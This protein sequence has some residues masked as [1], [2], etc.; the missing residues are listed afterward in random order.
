MFIGICTAIGGAYG[1]TDGFKGTWSWSGFTQGAL[2]G[3]AIGTGLVG[4]NMLTCFDQPIMSAFNAV[5]PGG[6][7]TQ[8]GVLV[9]GTP[10][11]SI[12]TNGWQVLGWSGAFAGAGAVIG[13]DGVLPPSLSLPDSKPT[14]PSMPNCGPTC[15]PI[16]PTDYVAIQYASAHQLSNPEMSYYVRRVGYAVNA[17][18]A[19]I[20]G[21]DR[22]RSEQE[23]LIEAGDTSTPYDRCTHGSAMGYIA[24]DVQYFRN[25][26]QIDPG[27]V[28]NAARGIDAIGGVG[29]YNDVR[30]MT[31]IDL[32]SNNS[33]WVVR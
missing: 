27:I 20:V 5:F 12:G 3:A 14:G 15:G 26:D 8:F 2:V 23:A 6:F 25:G 19:R 16:R 30:R 24:A 13:S 33:N 1:G 28:G 11:A 10:V 17:N 31:H 18:I 32:R 4:L 29:V 22:T 9:N 7:N 21:G